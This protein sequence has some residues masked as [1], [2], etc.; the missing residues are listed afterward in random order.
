MGQVKEYIKIAIKSLRT[1]PL[2]SWLTMIGVVIGIFLIIS[3]LSLS[4]GDKKS[5]RSRRYYSYDL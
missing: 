3:L 4:G 5:K 1:R 2:R